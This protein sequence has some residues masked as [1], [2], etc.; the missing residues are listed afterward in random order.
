MNND[1]VSISTVASHNV[2]VDVTNPEVLALEAEPAVVAHPLCLHHYLLNSQLTRG[3]RGD[4]GP[5]L[6]VISQLTLL[7]MLYRSLFSKLDYLK[8][9]CAH[10]TPDIVRLTESWLDD[11][12]TN[13]ELLIPASI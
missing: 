7:F 13:E 5:S 11:G 12:I 10:H 4:N 9:E 6:S 8:T 1:Y 3:I 2:A